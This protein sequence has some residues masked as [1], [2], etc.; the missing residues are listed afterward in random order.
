LDFDIPIGSVGDVY[1]RYMVRIEE[2]RQAVRIIDQC[3]SQIPAEGPIRTQTPFFVRPPVG[4]AYAAVE[5]P[6][7]ELGF[8]IVSDGGIAP[9]RCKIRAPSFINLTAI[10]DMVV[11]GKMGDLIT[12]FGSLDIVLG[13][14]D[15]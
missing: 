11:G 10:R 1:D 9:Y 13:E 4:E 7:G 3:I 14:V 8:Y 5:A 12:V 2:M 6:K 15:R